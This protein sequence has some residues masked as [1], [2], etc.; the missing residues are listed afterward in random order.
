VP[1]TRE[2]LQQ[3]REAWERVRERGAHRPG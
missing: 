1:D 3:I 2:E